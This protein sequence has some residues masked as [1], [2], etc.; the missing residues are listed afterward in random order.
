M[1][2]SKNKIVLPSSFKLENYNGMDRL[3]ALGWLFQLE[4]RYQLYSSIDGFIDS[5]H[6][7]TIEDKKNFLNLIIK[8]YFNDPFKLDR[9]YT[10]FSSNHNEN[11]DIFIYSEYEELPKM[12]VSGAIRPMTANDFHL[13]YE[14]YGVLFHNDRDD[15][16]F[17]KK[18]IRYDSDFNNIKSIPM[19]VDLSLS[20]E[21]LENE[22]KRNLAYLRAEIKEVLP[23]KNLANHKLAD[24]ASYKLLAYIDLYLWSCIND[25]CLKKP[26]LIRT[27]QLNY[28]DSTL[29]KTIDPIVNRLFNSHGIKGDDFDFPS[30]LFEEL[31][32]LALLNSEISR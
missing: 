31:S 16:P 29:R 28:S 23:V 9:N 20:D 25:F 18:I 21:T 17:F 4:A 8:D 30:Q 2:K 14:L 15:E 6:T 22:F 26:M 7:L 1:K 12:I 3:S 13:N 24:W 32:I 5:S 11:V 27:L 10:F 19:Y